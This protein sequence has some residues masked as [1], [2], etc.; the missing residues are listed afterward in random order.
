MAYVVERLKKTDK[1]LAIAICNILKTAYDPAVS[2][3]FVLQDNSYKKFFFSTMD[4]PAYATYYVYDVNAKELAGFACFQIMEEI[5]FLKHIV[6]NN[7]LRGEKIGTKL[8]THGINDI[9]AK[10]RQLSLF[11]LHVFEKNSKALSWYLSIGMKMIECN[12]WYD[13][14]S[15]LNSIDTTGGEKKKM[16]S[17]RRDSFG[18]VQVYDE[19]NFVGNILAYH[20]FILRNITYLS[21]IDKLVKFASSHRISSIGLSSEN[22]LPYNLVDTSILLSVP[23]N[24]LNLS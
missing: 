20:T 8:L 23:L 12:Y 19:D 1:K 10:N 7:R 17:C 15:K 18:F 5:L 22:R 11:Q 6:V 16:F 9:K 13:L 3:F 21:A 24:K 2:K 4:H 14:T